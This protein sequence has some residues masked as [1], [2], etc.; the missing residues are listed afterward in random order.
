MLCKKYPNKKV[1]FGVI[2]R[3]YP[4]LNITPEYAVVMGKGLAS[5]YVE[6]NGHIELA[7]TLELVRK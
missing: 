7:F 6:N 2:A 4:R 1:M 3:D 5:M